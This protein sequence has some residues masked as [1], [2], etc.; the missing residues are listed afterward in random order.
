MTPRR[1][2]RRTPWAWT[3]FPFTTVTCR[4]VPQV[5]ISLNR[6]QTLGVKTEAAASRSMSRTIRAVGTIEA[7][8]RGLYTVSP[9][10]EGW[11]TTL[12]V[13]TTRR[14]GQ[15]RSTAARR[16]QP[17]TG[18]RTGGIPG[19]G[20][21]LAVDARCVAG[22]PGQHAVTGRGRFAAPA[23]LGHCGCRPRR[24]QGGEGRPAFTAAAL[25]RGRRG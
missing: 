15:A 7:S 12:H 10:F 23:Q 17:G 14:H 19:R 8:E 5:K 20:A 9:K 3:T 2:R 13:N 25:T 6:L 22:G 1:C 16:L 4:T 11:I 21:D 18:H 24:T